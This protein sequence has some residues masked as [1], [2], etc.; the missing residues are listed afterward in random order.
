MLRIINLYKES[1]SNLQRTVWMLALVTFIN[2][3]GSIVILF[4]SLYLTKELHF[5]I[6]DAGITMSF[7]GMGGILGAYTGGWLADKKNASDILIFS[8]V[9][10]GCILLF[11]LLAK[12]PIAI[13]TVIFLYALVS[14]MFR[15]VA[16]KATITFSSVQNRTRSLS[17]NRLA[18]NLGFTLGPAAGGFIA[19][20]AGY[21]WLCIM[22]ACTSFVA[23]AILYLFLPKETGISTGSEIIQHSRDSSAYRDKYFLL[24]ILLVT[25]FGTGFFQL[26]VSV[27]QYLSTQCKYHE[28][29]IGL[30]LGLNG[31]L[32][33]VMEMPLIT[34]LEKNSQN[35]F[36]YIIAGAVCVSLAF[37]MLKY[38]SGMMVFSVA[39]IFIITLSEILC[40]PFMMNYA[41]SRPI[42]ERQGQYG[43]LYSI[44]YSIAHIIAPLLGLG[45]AD[46]YG[47]DSMFSFFIV[48]GVVTAGGFILLERYKKRLT[49]R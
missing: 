44:A 18:I 45:L 36:N 29:T 15:P 43:A 40:M 1:F 3:S 24:F 23:A 16:A 49:V 27:P 48:L 13:A 30:L 38:G 26:L 5:S 35:K 20:Y 41:L 22:D 17:L 14:D 7:Y 31:L 6:A 28:D 2:R 37:V 25:L 11:I 33:V 4:T 47:F 21:K 8:L 19:L 42:K 10:S 32:V 46:A 9:L 39:Y 34:K 12:T